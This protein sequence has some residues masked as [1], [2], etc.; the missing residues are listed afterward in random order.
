MQVNRNEKS[1]LK[2]LKQNC[3]IIGI[4]IKRKETECDKTRRHSKN[5]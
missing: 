4:I 2:F 1:F 5:Q 3:R